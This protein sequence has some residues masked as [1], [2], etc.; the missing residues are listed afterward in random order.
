MRLKQNSIISA[1]AI[2][3]LLL[4][5]IAF[6]DDATTSTSTLISLATTTPASLSATSTPTTSLGLLAPQIPAII[7]AVKDAK[8]KLST[9]ALNHALSPVYKKNTKKLL[10]YNLG[11]KD[12]ALAILDP[13]TNNT[14]ITIGRL[15]GKSMVFP[16][17]AVDV[18]LTTFNGV[19]S[20]FQV[21]MP[22]NGKIIALKYLISTTESGSKAAIEKGLSEAVYVPYSS[23]FS[24]PDVLTY[25][26]NYLNNIINTVSN[27]LQ[28]L[29]SRAVPGQT[30][31][32][33]IPPAM[34]K[35]LV[36]AEHTDTTQVLYGN[37]IQGTI[38]QLNIL[39]ALNEGDAFKYSVSTASARGIAQ[40]IPSTYTSLVQ[41]HPEVNLIPDFAAGMSDHENSIKAM[42]LLLDD[43]A[44]AVRVKAAQG[45]VAS[46]VF[47]YGAA[48]YNG[49]TT[50][51]ANAVNLFGS[52]WS[53]DKS[54]QINALQGR[55]NS[56]TS[57]IKS[58]KAKI[59]STTDKKT[60]ASLQAQ[61]TSTQS[62]FNSNSGQL[63]DLKSASLKNETVNYLAKI[64]KVIQYF[65]GQQQS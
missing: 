62:D 24:Q 51:V 17:P 29:P 44:G 46:R 59:K 8:A 5:N 41:R 40:F 19:N 45:F 22:A 36:Y 1:A 52:S 4:A 57:Q 63:S 61:L 31:T 49:G 7:Q 10:R 27:E 13:E 15:N 48:S 32:Q 34:I 20:K 42:Y 2:S 58:L 14:I 18:K 37:D 35:A 9:I 53:D 60:K 65:N 12:I 26:A 25:G 47:E 3:G 39:L 50:R 6:A 21:N 28:N 54:G 43:Y 56:L 23:D 38:N 16:D 33:A 11:D 55:V 64:Y 30:I